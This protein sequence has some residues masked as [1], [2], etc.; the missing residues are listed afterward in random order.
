M[1]LLCHNAPPDWHP[2]SDELKARALGAA[3]YCQ[4]QNVDL[5]KLALGFCLAQKDVPTTLVSCVNTEQM[6]SNL[7][8]LQD[9]LSAA[10]EKVLGTVLANFFPSST[11][12]EGVEKAAFDA[13]KR[14]EA[15][16]GGGGCGL[17]AAVGLA[18]G[19]AVAFGRFS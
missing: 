2:A 5:A 9:G 6:A 3:A 18:A 19:A 10:E 11:H 8:V 1:G 15:G 16:A 7:A 12:W 13:R 14:E 4:S 17:A